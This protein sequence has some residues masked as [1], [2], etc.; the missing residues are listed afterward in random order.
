VT[1]SAATPPPAG[2]AHLLLMRHGETAWNVEGRIQGHTDTPLSER[3]LA[4]AQELVLVLREEPI[5]AVYSSDLGRARETAAPLAR[6]RGLAL[7]IEP[8][9]RERGFGLFEGHTYDEAQARW[10]AEYAIWQRRE[11]AYAVPGGE[12][13]LELRSR[14]LA[15][16]AAIAAAHDGATVAVITHGGVLDAVFRAARG[17]PWEVPRSH[18][19]PNAAVNR[20]DVAWPGPRLSVTRWAGEPAGPV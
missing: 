16:L 17:I 2:R 7:Q 3:G 18:R 11:P 9:L 19:L 20:V 15:S 1:A 8:R 13:Y 12:S 14:V 5:A 10:P 6:E 4:Q